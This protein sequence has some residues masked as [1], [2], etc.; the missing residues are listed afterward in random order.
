MK[1]AEIDRCQ[2][3]LC[4]LYE[5]LADGVISRD[6]YQDLKKTYAKRK[7][8]AEEQAEAIREEMLMCGKVSQG[9]FVELTAAQL[10][11][12]SLRN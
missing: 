8:E 4:S 9:N 7:A 2:T 5:S 1:E 10:F 11:R 6:E 3:L 12:K